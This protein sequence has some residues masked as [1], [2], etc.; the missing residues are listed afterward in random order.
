MPHTLPDDPRA[1][2]I[3]WRS[4]GGLE[5]EGAGDPDLV[6]R[7]DGSVTVGERFGGTTAQISEERLQSLLDQIIDEHRLAQ[8]DAGRVQAAVEEA[9]LRAP[10]DGEETIP[11]A[12]G[13]PYVDAGDTHVVVNADGTRHEARWQG[14]FAAA[15]EHPD[16]QELQDLRA[17]EQ[18]LVELAMSVAAGEDG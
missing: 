17:V 14:L 3:E 6:V 11:A 15:R 1:P 8:F 4:S 16:V 18:T 9:A 12:S 2:V 10:A 13:G 7:A 5:A